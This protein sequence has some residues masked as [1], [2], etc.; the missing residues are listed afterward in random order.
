MFSLFTVPL[1]AFVMSYFGY[2]ATVSSGAGIVMVAVI[3]L[4]YLEGDTEHYVKFLLYGPIG[5]F[6][7]NE[8]NETKLIAHSNHNIILKTVNKHLHDN[9]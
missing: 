4:S 3:I 8:T 5:E 6:N 7:S 1:G 2:Q 9:I